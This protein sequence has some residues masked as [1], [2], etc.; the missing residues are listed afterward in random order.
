[1]QRWNVCIEGGDCSRNWK[2]YKSREKILAGLEKKSGCCCRVP[3]GGVVL[4]E[5]PVCPPGSRVAQLSVQS[6]SG[7]GQRESLHCP[8][9]SVVV[10]PLPPGPGAEGSDSPEGPWGQDSGPG[11]P[12]L[13]FCKSKASL[14]PNDRSQQ[15]LPRLWA[16]FSRAASGTHSFLPAALA[17]LRCCWGCCCFIPL[18]LRGR[19]HQYCR[20]AYKAVKGEMGI[21]TLVSH[22]CYFQLQMENGMSTVMMLCHCLGQWISAACSCSH[23]VHEWPCPVSVAG[24]G[25]WVLNPFCNIW[26]NKSEEF[27]LF[28]Y[29]K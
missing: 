3:G 27:C 12:S 28:E 25:S 23:R 7:A 8:S 14:C 26:F 9:R 1:M 4:S 10:T 19:S 11:M 21:F 13:S 17:A 6:H 29:Q 5:L 24:L 15:P 20:L 18:L 16:A 22:S 2:L